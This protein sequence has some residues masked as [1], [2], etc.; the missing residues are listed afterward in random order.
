M[1]G[2]FSASDK[3]QQGHQ[4]GQDDWEFTL[5]DIPLK[6]IGAATPAVGTR[7]TSHSDLG[8]GTTI[9][10]TD[11]WEN[12]RKRMDNLQKKQGKVPPTDTHHSP[13]TPRRRLRFGGNRKKGAG[14]K[15]AKT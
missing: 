1:G 2:L 8:S 9:P 10:D 13:E 15:P 5:E 4:Q 7:F 12:E 11:P 3:Q 14:T 6:D